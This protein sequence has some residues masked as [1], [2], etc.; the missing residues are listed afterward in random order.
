MLKKIKWSPEMRRDV[1]FEVFKRLG[2]TVFDK[3]DK[4]FWMPTVYMPPMSDGH[5]FR[6]TAAVNAVF[7]AAQHAV[8]VPVDLRRASFSAIECVTPKQYGIKAHLE[9]YRSESSAKS[10]V[11]SSVEQPSTSIEQ[12]VEPASFYTVLRE[13]ERRIATLEAQAKVTDEILLELIDKLERPKLAEQP[14]LVAPTVTAPVV[15][16]PGLTAPIAVPVKTKTVVRK[17][18]PKEPKPTPKVFTPPP[19]PV[20]KDPIRRITIVGVHQCYHRTW[21]EKL[22]TPENSRF[23]FTFVSNEKANSGCRN[24]KK[25]DHSFLIVDKLAHSTQ[26]QYEKNAKHPSSK[27]TTIVKGNY[28]SFVEAFESFKAQLKSVNV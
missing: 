17:K 23:R 27:S 10:E 4:R 21:Q 24:P 9:L 16:V 5:D 1:F 26:D 2:P 11:S 18:P 14:T 20:E 22:N 15:P 12:Q 25:A 7:Q 8:G 13:L 19:P 28:S 3:S 6:R